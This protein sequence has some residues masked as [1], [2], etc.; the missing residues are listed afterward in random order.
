[1]I[2]FK[3]CNKCHGDLYLKEDMYGSFFQCLQCGRIVEVK[4]PEPGS[5]KEMIS[6]AA[7]LAA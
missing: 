5:D 6:Q 7:K 1:M 3:G 2:Y 4:V